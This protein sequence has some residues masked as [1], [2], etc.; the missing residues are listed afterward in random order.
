[1]TNLVKAI[2]GAL[3]VLAVLLLAVFCPAQTNPNLPPTWVYARAY[4]YP[5]IVGQS[6]NTYTFN[7]GVCNYSPYNNGTSAPFFVFSGY[8]STT[9]VF[10]P[11]AIIDAN[12]SN[13]EIVT[14]TSTTQSTASCGFAASTVNSHTSFTLAS[15]TAGLQEAIVTQFQTSPVFDV[16]LDQYWYG[17]VAGLP[18]SPSASSIILSVAGNSNVGIVDSTT[19]PWTYY[20]YNGTSYTVCASNQTVPTLAEGAGA[21]GT[22]TGVSIVGTGLSGIVKITTGGTAPTASATIFTLTWPAIASGGF[23]YAPACTISPIKTSSATH[24]YTGTNASVAG[25]PAVDTYTSTTTALSNT[26]A[27]EW[28]Y[29]CR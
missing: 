6:P 26:T 10:F 16:V 18:G 12:A 5:Q 22:P 13:S 19:S 14:P 21:G 27:Y 11:V 9:Q 8:Q 23:Q 1:M 28:S 15:G 3:A 17:L 25:P 24:P 29:T 20:C 7:G 4:N 2:Q